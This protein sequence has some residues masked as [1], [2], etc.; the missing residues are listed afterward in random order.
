MASAW[1]LLKL[2]RRAT[3]LR[4]GRCQ[5]LAGNT[6][7]RPQIDAGT[8]N[9]TR[10]T[11]GCDNKQDEWAEKRESISMHNYLGGAGK[12]SHSSRRW[13][14]W[15]CSPP[16]SP[17]VLDVPCDSLL[18]SVPT[19]F[20]RE[21]G[22]SILAGTGG[23]CAEVDGPLL[24]GSLWLRSRRLNERAVLCSGFTGKRGRGGSK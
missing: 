12:L 1:L 15:V 11:L 4:G 20:P 22:I 14:G 7:A 23:C 9:C 2:K 8:G 3:W 24:A 16:P 17:P 18:L 13:Q 19:C 6:W 21:Q 10:E 5:R